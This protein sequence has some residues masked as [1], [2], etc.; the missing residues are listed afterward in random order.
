MFELE[1]LR[2][3][4]QEHGQDL[5]KSA[6]SSAEGPPRPADLRLSGWATAASVAPRGALAATAHAVLVFLESEENHT[7]VRSI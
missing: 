5:P 6:L 3:V 1:A 7:E 4:A 2:E